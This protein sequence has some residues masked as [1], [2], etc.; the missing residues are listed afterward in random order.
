M[1]VFFV[2]EL[3]VASKR[4][5]FEILELEARIVFFFYDLVKFHISH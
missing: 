3:I 2:L 5:F 1:K 4:V